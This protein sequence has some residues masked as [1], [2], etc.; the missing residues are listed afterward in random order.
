MSVFIRCGLIVVLLLS[1]L[2]GAG[3]ARAGGIA[4]TTTADS[5]AV[6]GECSLREA[7]LAAN[8]GAEVDTCDGRG[9][10]P[11]IL[12]QPGQV[13]LLSLKGADGPE[14]G[15]LDLL[16]GMAIT[17]D[18]ANPAV[19]SAEGLGDRVLHINADAPV[20]LTGLEVRG[21]TAP[22]ALQQRGGGIY[23]EGG[24]VT[25]GAV[26]VAGNTSG[27]VGGGIFRQPGHDS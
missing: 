23:V 12:L 26:I 7:V 5:L 13:Y 10:T 19:I 22:E 20:T 18:P 1:W 6:D 4:V 2:A 21:G 27:N 8:A 9:D 17:G 24:D 15:D 14:A 3:P 11:E 16:A 25:L